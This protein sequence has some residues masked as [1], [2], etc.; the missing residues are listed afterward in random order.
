MEF[1]FRLDLNQSSEAKNVS[2]ETKIWV[3]EAKN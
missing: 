2:Y 3:S 1:K